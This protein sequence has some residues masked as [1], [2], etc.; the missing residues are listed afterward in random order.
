MISRHGRDKVVSLQ[1]L[2]T[3][4]RDVQKANKVV[5]FCHGC[6]DILHYGHVRH[7]EAARDMGDVLVVTVTP[8]RFINKG[9]GRPVFGEEHIS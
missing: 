2:S 3:I 1:A 7:L 9:P 5:V 6:F 4:V 8:D